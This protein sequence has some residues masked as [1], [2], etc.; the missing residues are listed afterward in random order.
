MKFLCDHMLIRLGKWLRAAGHDTDIVLTPISDHEVL[1]HALATTRL[2]ITRD[3]HFLQMK[4]ATPLLIYLVSND[5]EACMQELNQKIKINWIYAPFT[6]CLNCNSLLEQIDSHSALEQIP[7]HIRQKKKTF[8][9]CPKCHQFYWE[10]SHTERM[11]HQLQKWQE[12][13]LS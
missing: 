4:A 9:H 13:N 8:W 1:T 11:L 5:F 6:R 10:G 12:V 2:L 7:L 3:R